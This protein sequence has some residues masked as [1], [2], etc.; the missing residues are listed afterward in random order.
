MR[1]C[2]QVHDHNYSK[3]ARDKV[4]P[5]SLCVAWLNDGLDGVSV[6]VVSS[7]SGWF[8]WY[9]A[10]AAAAVCVWSQLSPKLLADMQVYMVVIHFPVSS[11]MCISKNLTTYTKNLNSAAWLISKEEQYIEWPGSKFCWLQKTVVAS[12]LLLS[13]ALSSTAPCMISSCLHPTQDPW[14]LVLAILSLCHVMTTDNTLHSTEL[15]PTQIGLCT[16]M[17]LTVDLHDYG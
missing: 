1:E 13:P 16:L 10:G 11:G 14:L 5:D 12:R 7:Y 17:F 15:K 9:A 8:I 6:G 3:H 2:Q 4:A